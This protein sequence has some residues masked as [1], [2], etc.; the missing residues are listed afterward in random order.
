MIKNVHF[1]TKRFILRDI[2]LSDAKGMFALD[3]DPEVHE[4]LGKKPIST[5]QESEDII[6]H[7]R[8][9]Y[10]DNGLGRLA[11][12][13]KETNEFIG[14]TGIKYEEA[15]REF[16]YYDL[17]YR[18]RKKF[19]KQGIAT[20]TALASLKYGFETLS[21]KEIF[22]A[23]D[24]TNIG[25]NKILKKIGMEYVEQFDFEGDLHNWYVITKSQWQKLNR[26]I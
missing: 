6:R 2:E 4:Y 23:A 3:S 18:L 5:L 12:I 19:W 10:V 7:I 1:E 9:Q 24:V 14:W 16:P 21:L 20:E 11:I 22:A 15:V 8:K 26:F 13:D 17:G 25:S